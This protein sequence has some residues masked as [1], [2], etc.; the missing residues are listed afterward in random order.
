[1]KALK[2]I[3]ET[4]SKGHVRIQWIDLALFFCLCFDLRERK[5]I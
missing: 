2:T 4:F 1:M 3:L 5:E